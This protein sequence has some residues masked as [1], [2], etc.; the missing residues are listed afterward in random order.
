MEAVPIMG[1]LL[2]GSWTLRVEVTAVPMVEGA[3]VAGGE[4]ECSEGTRDV[5]TYKLEV[6]AA[7]AAV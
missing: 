7:A 5:W 1:L 2:C 6:P 3:A 4:I